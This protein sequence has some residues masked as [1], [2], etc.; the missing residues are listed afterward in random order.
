MNFDLVSV[1][2][3]A[4]TAMLVAALVGLFSMHKNVVELQAEVRQLRRTIA[5]GP[6]TSELMARV[7]MLDRDV[8]FLK[9][10]IM[11]EDKP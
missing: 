3:S 7:N 11:K 9:E 5:A 4:I 1:F 8:E 2:Q 10:Q 6:S